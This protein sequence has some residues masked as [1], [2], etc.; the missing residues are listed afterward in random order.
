MNKN[1]IEVEF[2]KYISIDEKPYYLFQPKEL[3]KEPLLVS[4]IDYPKK[5]EEL[6]PE[7]KINIYIQGIDKLD[8]KWI[9][10]NIKWQI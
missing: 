6:M 4:C 2:K 3:F 10:N 8:N 9:I 1:Y 7:E 5:I